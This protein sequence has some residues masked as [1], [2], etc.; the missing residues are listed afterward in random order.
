LACGQPAPP[1]AAEPTAPASLVADGPRL[2]VSD[3]TGGAIVVID[4]AVGEVLARLPVGKRPR[5]L[6]V[7]HD[8]R[9]LFVALSGSPIAGPG[10]DEAT[11]PPADRSADGIGVID[12]TT[13]RLT[14][15]LKSGQDPE[16][17]DLSPD[18]TVLYV[19]NEDAAEMSVVDVGTGTVRSRVKVGEEPE[20]VTVRPG[21]REVYVT[22]E[23]DNEVVAID[24]ASGAITARLKTGLRPRAVVFTA[25]GAT[26]FVTNENDATIA[27]VDAVRHG[28]AGRVRVPQ[29][30]GAPIRRG[31]W[32]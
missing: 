25:D 11:L 4:P 31:R 19:S 26:A 30:S 12:L 24:T 6:R 20:G 21:G 3:E 15:V 28:I 8:G 7:S 32:A 27:V 29:A 17:F 23:A 22:C 1:P 10:V 16:S 2:Y 9:Q 18:G 14:R 13:G 5:G